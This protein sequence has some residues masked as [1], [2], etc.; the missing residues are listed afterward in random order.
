MASRSAR[1]ARWWICATTIWWKIQDQ[2]DEFASQMSLALSSYTVESTDAGAILPQQG[3][4]VDLAAL[5]SGNKVTLT[6]YGCGVG[7]R[8]DH[9][10]S[11]RR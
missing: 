8:A 10:L 2:L 7:R 4:E 5:Q 6:L 3:L 1:W 11:A 9:Q